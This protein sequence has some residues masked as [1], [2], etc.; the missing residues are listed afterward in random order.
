M[1]VI[2]YRWENVYV[3]IEIEAFRKVKENE[4]GEVW[5]RRLH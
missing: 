2:T 4:C 1:F 3:D 5:D